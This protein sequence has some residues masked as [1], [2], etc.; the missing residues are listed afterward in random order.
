MK[1]LSEG[2]YI[3]Q[4]VWK[5]ISLILIVFI[6]FL[7]VVFWYDLGLQEIAERQGTYIEKDNGFIDVYANGD[8]YHFHENPKTQK[9]MRVTY[10]GKMTTY[11]LSTMSRSEFIEALENK[12][13]TERKE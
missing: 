5:P 6:A 7:A 3:W 11:I 8:L 2:K 9:M 1:E 10:N 13:F 12:G 4:S